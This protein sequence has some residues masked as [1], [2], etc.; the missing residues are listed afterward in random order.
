VY[1]HGYSPFV[2]LSSRVIVL[3]GAGLAGLASPAADFSSLF[4]AAFSVSMRIWER[5]D[6]RC[7]IRIILHGGGHLPWYRHKFKTG[8]RF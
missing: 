8:H 5:L 7:R 3:R 2:E 6:F 4:A 1:S